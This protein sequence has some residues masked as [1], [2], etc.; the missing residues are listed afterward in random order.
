MIIIVAK[1]LKYRML[2]ALRMMFALA[3]LIILI[4]QLVSAIRSVEIN[5]E[6]KEEYPGGNPIKVEQDVT[7]HEHDHESTLD[8]LLK[9]LK[10]YYR[11]E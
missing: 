9:K 1:K 4:V 7:T 11:G 5:N 10:D 6:L 2:Q 8:S 3:I